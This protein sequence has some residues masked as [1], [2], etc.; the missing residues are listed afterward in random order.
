MQENR[1]SSFHTDGTERRAYAR[2]CPDMDVRELVPGK[3]AYRVR[4]ISAG[5]MRCEADLPHKPGLLVV[6]EIDLKNGLM[7]FSAPARV[8]RSVHTELGHELSF[9]FMMPQVQLIPY[10][11][12][13]SSTADRR[14]PTA[15]RRPL[16]ADR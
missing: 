2:F 5:G 15:D 6:L 11:S 9:Q 7:P 13:T 16:T 4:S 14:P 1:A 10:I 3:Q 8:V 12:D